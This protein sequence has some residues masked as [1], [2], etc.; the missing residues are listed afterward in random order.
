MKGGWAP[1]WMDQSPSTCQSALDSHVCKK[2]ESGVSSR[3][4]QSDGQSLR[5]LPA[6]IR[7]RAEWPAL[8]PQGRSVPV[9][10]GNSEEARMP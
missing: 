5:H 9:S 8:Q 1:A 2:S 3:A 10:S 4:G 7:G 6:D